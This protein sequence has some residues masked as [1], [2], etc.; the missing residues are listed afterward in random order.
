MTHRH[1][2]ITRHKR[3]E[4]LTVPLFKL[5]RGNMVFNRLSGFFRFLSLQKKCLFIITVVYLTFVNSAL[6]EVASEKGYIEIE[7][8]RFIWIE[9]DIVDPNAPT[10]IL[11]N[12]MTYTTESWGRDNRAILK[13]GYNTLRYDM[14][15]QGRTLV[16]NPQPEAPI[17]YLQQVHDL[18]LLIEQ[19]NLSKNVHLAGL[20]YGGGIAGALA[21]YEPEFTEEHIN[22]VVMLVP[23]TAPIKAQEDRI[24]KEIEFWIRWSPLAFEYF[25]ADEAGKQVLKDNLYNTILRRMVMYEFFWAEPQDI[26]LPSIVHVHQRLDSIYQMTLGLQGLNLADMAKDYRGGVPITLIASVMDKFIPHYPRKTAPL[27]NF[28]YNL[29]VD[30]R[31]SLWLFNGTEHKITRQIPETI[32]ETLQFIERSTRDARLIPK[33]MEFHVSMPFKFITANYPEDVGPPTELISAALCE[34]Y[35]D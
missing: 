27:M 22:S 5:V 34:A 9:R 12:G 1:K 13:K 24:S 8:G 18:K 23:F 17:S 21:M 32:A 6:A 4:D 15:G 26:A 28:W 2:L 25:K 16:K 19:L 3:L 35:L 31:H 10:F 20:S 11:L 33:G 30:Q 14:W 7:P 29:D